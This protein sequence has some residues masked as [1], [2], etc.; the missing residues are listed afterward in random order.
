MNIFSASECGGEKENQYSKEWSIVARAQRPKFADVAETAGWRERKE[1][2]SLARAWITTHEHASAYKGWY[3]S[4][5]WIDRRIDD[6]LEK[7]DRR[8]KYI[9]YPAAGVPKWY[10]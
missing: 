5:S 3:T 8:T 2:F 4:K 6:C 10:T 1:L 7:K 9:H